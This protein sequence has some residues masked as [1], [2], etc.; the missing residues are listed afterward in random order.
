[1]GLVNIFLCHGEKDRALA[2]A[3]VRRLEGA[4]ARVALDELPA[5]QTVNAAW[6]EGLG[7]DAVLA[8][9]SESAVPAKLKRED[10]AGVLEHVEGNAEPPVGWVLAGECAFPHLLRRNTRLFFDGADLR[11]IERWALSLREVEKGFEPARL[12][13]FS[14]RGEELERL[15]EWLV[16][17]AGTAVV[18][19]GAGSGKSCLAQEFARAAGGHFHE[20]L[21]LGCGGRS[22]TFLQ[23]EMARC[24]DWEQRRR[25]VVLEDADVPFPEIP[26]A[27]RTSVLIT[28]REWWPERAVLLGE[29]R[30]AAVRAPVEEEMLRLWEAMTVCRRGA[31]P[32]ALAA[33]IAG[34]SERAAEEA[35]DRLAA[36]RS[37]DPLDAAGKYFRRPEGGE[38][39]WLRRR[40]A[41]VLD[42]VFGDHRQRR[43]QCKEWLG[44]WESAWRWAKEED[45]RL[46]ASLG[47]RGF[48]FLKEMEWLYEEMEVLEE[49]LEA[50]EFRGDATV[51]EE[52]RYEMSWIPG[53]RSRLRLSG[54][55][56]QL[57]F[58]FG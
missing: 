1:M 32:L 27:K 33:E 34:L 15:W 3:I 17:E 36:G 6:E 35:A 51:E 29:E 9:L 22:E 47:L 58:D 23:G 26:P 43:E 16:D 57:G 54:G 55:G 2:Q 48:R 8:V 52:C 28:T 41:E 46:A 37:I 53:V 13:W 14:G 31:V 19:G 40:H 45:W 21:W 7:S 20:I 50:A 4:G 11:R 10:W 18:S 39:E 42:C 5:G 24:K 30:E 25:L 12:P 44:E 49:L 56:E 38:A